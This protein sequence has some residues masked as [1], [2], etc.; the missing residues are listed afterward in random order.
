MVLKRCTF[1]CV[2]EWLNSM[3]KDLEDV[4]PAEIPWDALR[5]LISESIFGGKIDNDYD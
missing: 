3:G 2:D 4:N 1:D 5:T